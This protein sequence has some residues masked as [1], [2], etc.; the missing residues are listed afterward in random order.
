MFARLALAALL[1]VAA[2]AAAVELVDL[3]LDSKP[4]KYGPKN[5]VQSEKQDFALSDPGVLTLA[6]VID[7]VHKDARGGFTL[8]E[9]NLRNFTVGRGIFQERIPD[10][11]IPGQMRRFTQKWLCPP[12]TDPLRLRATVTAPHRPDG[13]DQL[14]ASQRLVIGF[15]P[16]DKVS[17]EPGPPPE[18]DVAGKWYH[19][20]QNAVWTLTPKGDGT[21]AA[22]EKGYDNATGTARVKGRK[23][24][25][26]F[27]TTTAKGKQV[28]GVTVV[29]VKP[30]GT[31]AEGWSVGEGGIGGE[32][33]SAAPGTAA[34]PVSKK[35]P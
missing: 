7:P 33:W 4:R 24:Y 31:H 9:V 14:G 8:D 6:H 21:Y 3:K 32:R 20:E 19:G 5:P 25:I 26:D 23:V 1:A 28:R 12:R 22:A 34:K 29:E 30:D 11:A 18:V 17:G 35:A 2:P 27:V 10:S 16:F 13:S 15:V